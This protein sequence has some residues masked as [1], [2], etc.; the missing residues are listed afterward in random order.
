[1]KTEREIREKIEEYMDRLT[2]LKRNGFVIGGGDDAREYEGFI[3]ALLWVV[4]D[5][6][7]RLR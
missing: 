2:A 7:G 6:G 3:D 1:M 5:N 4:G